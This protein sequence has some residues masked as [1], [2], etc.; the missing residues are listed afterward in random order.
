MV[1][2]LSYSELSRSSRRS[3]AVC[4]QWEALSSFIKELSLPQLEREQLE[5]L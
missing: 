4:R 2:T 1:S 5:H 3:S